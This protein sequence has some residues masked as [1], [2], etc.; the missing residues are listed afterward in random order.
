M[1]M[2]IQEIIAL[3]NEVASQAPDMN[4]AVKGGSGSRLLPAGY[5]YC[6]LVEYIEFG[7]QP[8]E[9][10]GKAKDPALEVQLGFALYNTADRVY[11][12]EDGSPYILR[13][14]SMAMSQ[15]EKA[16][17][18]LLFKALNW[19]QTA[20]HF[21]QLLTQ[22]FLAKIV[23]EPKSKAEPDKVVSRID[24]KG[25]LPPVDTVSGAPHPI[26][27]ARVEDLKVFFWDRP[28][29]AGWDAL[30]IDGTYDAKDGKPAQSKNVLQETMLK[31][32]DF[33]GSA[34][35]QLLFGDAV[36]ALPTASTPVV[37]A[38]ALPVAPSAP[39]AVPVAPAVPEVAGAVPLA[40][41]A[42]PSV[43][44]APVSGP[45]AALP[46]ET[47][48]P[49]VSASSVPTSHFEVAIPSMPVMPSIPAIPALPV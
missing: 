45:A 7:K 29:K 5:A 8:Q 36:P 25:F 41:P 24:L 15:N 35:Q 19:K 2:T 37:A 6:R 4:V 32:T 47:G 12:N 43:P 38:A 26:P 27:E 11:Q 30:F 23:H 9:F 16:R 10:N 31:A 28:T 46:P 3:A 34:L 40:Q 1:S 18:Y 49:A 39:P 13:P 48:S 44:V 20:T 14:Y 22:G 33:Q 21:G 17:A 42:V